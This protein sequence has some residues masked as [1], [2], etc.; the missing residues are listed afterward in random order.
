MKIHPNNLLILLLL[1]AILAGCGRADADREANRLFVEAYQL[2]EAAN[3]SEIDDPAGSYG[4]YLRA[5][6]KIDQIIANYPGTSVAVDVAQRR[7][8][9]GE[10]TIGELR[11]KVPRLAAKSRALEDFHNLALHLAGMEDDEEHFTRKLGHARLLHDRGFADRHEE[12]L[13]ELAGRAERQWNRE[14]TDRFYFELSTHYAEL[15]RWEESLRFTDLIQDHSLLS[16][17]LL[18][19]LDSGFIGEAPVRLFQRIT[20]YLDY[21]NPVIRI[22][23][24]DRL[25]DG[26]LA[27]GYRPQAVAILQEDLPEPSDSRNLDHLNSLARLS[28]TLGQHGEYDLSRAVIGLIGRTDPNY[29]DFA[30]RDLAVAMARRGEP[31]KGITFAGEFNRVH[32][33]HTAFTS[34][35]LSMAES[36]SLQG[37]LQLLER[38]P[39]NLAERTDVLLRIAL[40]AADQGDLA[41]SLLNAA[42]PGI[43]S[44]EAPMIRTGLYIRVAEIHLQRNRRS[45]AA[46]AMETAEEH[47]A[48]VSD[49]ENINQTVASIIRTW[50]SLG[51]P[52]RALDAATWYRMDHPSFERKAPDLFAHAINRGYH[53]FARTLAGMTERRPYF[54]YVLVSAYLDH[55]MISQPSELAY[56][57]RDFYWRSRALSLLTMDLKT[58]VNLAT[59]ERAATDALLVMQRIRDRHT[60]KQ[61][62]FH[63]A[64]F[65]A[66]AELTMDQERRTL[67][68]ELLRQIEN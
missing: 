31:D 64:S 67:V 1:T 10:I 19:L 16:D 41:D 50:L 8:R 37:A 40:M 27:A 42:F 3:R 15:S 11:D 36:D 54:Q 43:A 32:F 9:I 33:R 59:A 61:A 46:E 14:L 26:M 4:Y 2:T 18:H 53:D 66:S 24:I 22:R 63:A 52:D 60:K 38:V 13:R 6:E 28:A 65:F 49:P 68:T 35:A 62:L 20:V 12:I 58:K 44:V 17:A 51:R 25:C 21:M 45:Q 34:I 47:A 48:A 7:T 56:E 23:L 39:R 29:A 5:V 30:R 55:G 57:I